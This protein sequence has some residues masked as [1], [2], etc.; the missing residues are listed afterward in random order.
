MKNTLS[1]HSFFKTSMLVVFLHLIMYP[2]IQIFSIWESLNYY[3]GRHSSATPSECTSPDIRL[4]F[5]LPAP[6]LY[7]RLLR[8]NVWKMVARIRAKT[9]SIGS[10]GR[11]S[12]ARHHGSLPSNLTKDCSRSRSELRYETVVGS[13]L[14]KCSHALYEITKRRSVVPPPLRS[15]AGPLAFGQP[16]CSERFAEITILY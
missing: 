3:T 11:F 8:R 1:P 4:V 2:F 16:A 14:T 6:S 5:L 7:S 10:T 13:L 12:P 15:S 9:W